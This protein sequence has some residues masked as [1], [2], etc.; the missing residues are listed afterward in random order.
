M[1]KHDH[2]ERCDG[3]ICF[4]SSR[5]ARSAIRKAKRNLKSRSQVPCRAYRCD[6]CGFW[7]LTKAPMSK[8]RRKLY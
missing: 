7:H 6:I 5:A 3:K 2:S 1:S 8:G 4:G